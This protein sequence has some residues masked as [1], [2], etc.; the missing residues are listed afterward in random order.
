MDEQDSLLLLFRQRQPPRQSR[1]SL[2]APTDDTPF[3]GV[4]PFSIMMVDKSA[5]MGY[6]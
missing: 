5:P 4:Y 2:E 6:T 3:D 1:Y